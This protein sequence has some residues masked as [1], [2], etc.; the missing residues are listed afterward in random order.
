MSKNYFGGKNKKLLEDAEEEYNV[1]SV[2][3]EE[4]KIPNYYHIFNGES[5]NVRKKTK[6]L[7][8]FSKAI[9]PGSRDSCAMSGGMAREMPWSTRTKTRHGLTKN[10]TVTA[11]GFAMLCF[12][13]ELRKVM[14]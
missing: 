1:S 5:G 3:E 2:R 14:L 6:I 7:K 12:M 8:K 11:T 10:L 4:A 9:T 13:T